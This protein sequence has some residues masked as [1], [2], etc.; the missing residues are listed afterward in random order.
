MQKNKHLKNSNKIKILLLIVLTIIVVLGV[1]Y[2]SYYL[3]N[4]YKTRKDNAEILGNV[5]INETDITGTKTER[6]LQL[7]ELQK[8]NEEIIGWLEI[9]GTNINYPVLQAS[10][11]DYYLTHNYKKE[12]SST[13]S[14]FLDKDFDLING[15]SN[16]LI[17]GH[18]SKSGLMF[19]DLM[20]YAK[21]DFYKEHTKVK[22]TTNKDDSLYEILSV[23]YSRVYYKS[24][25][26]VFRYYYF[27]NA[28][29]EQEYNDFVNNA[30]KV[31]L[32]DTGVTANYGEQL[33]TLSTCEYSQ[34]DGR[35]AIVCKKVE[36]EQ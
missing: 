9:E 10:D 28:N 16:Y 27:V 31:S 8:E 21:E 19:E 32:Y 18:R 7:E 35:F 14:I 30:K 26:N 13:G 17:Y 24:E 22:F 36:N 5:K 1:T 2:M 20:K 11:N 29:N 34:E 6:M 3:Y 12:K 4:N 15:S 25:K 33:L 23:F